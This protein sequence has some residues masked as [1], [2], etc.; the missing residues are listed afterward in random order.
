MPLSKLGP[1]LEDAGREGRA[2]GA[3]NVSSVEMIVGAVSAAEETN[4]PIIL[5]AAE[6]RLKT[7]PLSVLGPA[8][9]AAAQKARVGIAVQFDHGMTREA[10]LEALETGFTSVMFDGS[11]LPMA[12]NIART[13]EIA[14]LAHSFGAACEGEIG[15]LGV[16]E[17]GEKGT[18]AYTDPDEAVRFAGETGVDAL[19]ISI[20]N[21]HGVYAGTPHF[22][23]EIPEAIRARCAVPLVLHG[24]TGSGDEQFRKAVQCGIRKINIATAMFMADAAARR[25]VPRDD[26]F[27]MSEAA[28][29]AVKDTVLRHLRIFG[30][31]KES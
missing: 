7:T 13:R 12:E 28:L 18:L 4:T 30:I 5:Q 2:V 10:I 21:A 25:S 1:L 8:M 3:F 17:G 22:H 20:G 9:I 26:F 19:A 23:F 15:A 27:A 14:D 24:G 31:R 11:A 6:R 16:G 29:S